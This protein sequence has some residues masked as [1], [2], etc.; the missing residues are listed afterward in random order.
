[1]YRSVECTVPAGTEADD[2]YSETVKLAKG[3]LRR[4]SIRP[5]PG[6]NWEV[7]ARVRYREFSLFPIDDDEWVTLERDPINIETNWDSWDGTYDMT[8]EFCSPDARFQHKVNVEFEVDEKPTLQEILL[9]L[10]KG[11]F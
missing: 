2:P 9:R 10:V 8:V 6:P 4:V 3:T 5:A 1:M 11:A 7:Y